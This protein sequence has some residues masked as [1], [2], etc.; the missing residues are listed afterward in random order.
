MLRGI[1]G[2]DYLKLGL[3]AYRRDPKLDRD[4]AG[5]EQT[6]ER[7]SH[8]DLR[9]FFDD[10]VYRDRGLPELSILSVTPSRQEGQTGL[11]AGYLVAIVV[12]NDGYATADIPVTVRSATASQTERLRVPGQTSVSTRI[13][14]AGTPE[15]VEVNDGDVPETVTSVHTRELVLPRQ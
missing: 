2:D 13:V 5:L 6:L 4:P 14:F 7:F 8:K 1:L 15:L 3:Q 12:R 10:W 11:P 9:W